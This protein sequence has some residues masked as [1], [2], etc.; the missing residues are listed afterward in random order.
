MLPE[1]DDLPPR[2]LQ[3]LC[4]ETIALCVP[5]QLRAPVA[6][7]GERRLSVNGAGM[8]KA[9]IYKHSHAPTREHKVRTSS[10]AVDGY[11]Q[12]YPK[13]PAASVQSGPQ[14]AFRACVPP[15]I[16]SHAPRHRVARRA[17]RRWDDDG[18]RHDRQATD[19]TS[20]S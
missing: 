20:T 11:H 5:G 7:I 9:A 14:L 16:G 13:P 4:I 18:L 15:T 17:G 3:P 12:I 19:P 10:L 8:P 2:P 6:L 1:A